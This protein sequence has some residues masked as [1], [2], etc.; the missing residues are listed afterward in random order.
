M[1]DR[2]DLEDK[3]TDLEADRAAAE[4]AVQQEIG[5]EQLRTG[6]DPSHEKIRED[7]DLPTPDPSKLPPE[8]GGTQTDP[9]EVVDNKSEFDKKLKEDKNAQKE[10]AEEVKGENQPTKPATL[11]DSKGK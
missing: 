1:T 4:V 9:K 6:I 10:A 2:K 8:D 11:G 3:V 5:K 7:K